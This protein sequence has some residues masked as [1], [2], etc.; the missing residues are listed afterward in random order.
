MPGADKVPGDGAFEPIAGLMAK[1][2]RWLM[3]L[4]WM[5]GLLC[6]G[7]G[8]LPVVTK[9]ADPALLALGVALLALSRA[10][11]AASYARRHRC[12]HGEGGGGLAVPG[13]AGG[14]AGEGGSS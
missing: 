6:M 7:L 13:S 9:G 2:D 10:A 12:R 11:A 8:I 1:V 3:A 4:G 14:P 5:F